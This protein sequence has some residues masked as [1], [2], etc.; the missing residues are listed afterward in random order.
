MDNI[1]ATMPK[2]PYSGLVLYGDF[3]PNIQ[4]MMVRFQAPNFEIDVNAFYK[5]K[6]KVTCMIPRKLKLLKFYFIYFILL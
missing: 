6:Y 3:F 2:R 4:T 1:F 5:N